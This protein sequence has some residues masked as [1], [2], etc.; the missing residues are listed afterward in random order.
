MMSYEEWLRCIIDAAQNIASGRFQEVAWFPG[1][2]VRSSPEEAY[3][4]LMEDC[5][6]DLF[7]ETYGASLTQ[8]QLGAWQILRADLEK[9]YL[10]LPRH[11]DPKNVLKDP[12]WDVVRRSAEAFVHAFA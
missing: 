7:F 10:Q 1:G 5:T 3:Q 12:Q 9:Y 6:A 2:K 11:A 4:V 8:A